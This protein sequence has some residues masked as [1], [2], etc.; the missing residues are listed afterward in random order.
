[1][2]EILE[3]LSGEKARV[4]ND[5]GQAI[6]TCV[7]RTDTNHHAFNGCI[8]WHSS[9]H[10]VWAL[11]AIMRATG[12][13]E[14]RPLVE[15]ALAPEKLALEREYLRERPRFEMPYGRAWFLRLA[16]D[17]GKLTGSAALLPMADAM[18]GTLIAFYRQ[19]PPYPLS[20]SY[21]S[22]SWAYI[23][24]LDY[25]RFTAD[26]EAERE[27]LA[28]INAHFPFGEISC[29]YDLEH[30]HFMAVCTNLA[31]LA[32][33]IMTPEEFRA[34]AGGFFAKSGLPEPV[35]DPVNWHHYGLNFS[36]A[37]GLWDIYVSTGDP[38]FADAYARHFRASFDNPENWRGSYRG[39][40]HWVAQFGMFALQPLF[41]GQRPV[42]SAGKSR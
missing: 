29:S 15:D 35:T 11:N 27:I 22:A 7:S 6:A 10:G 18:L 28:S 2:P 13:D 9:V 33:R 25:A 19:R 20:G 14:Y 8:D 3:R 12:R 16:I 4:A 34:W 30:G 26:D 41:D 40:G 38:A 39:V 1:M 21:N 31:M 42:H 17:H 37:W 36:R 24:M 23:N 5:L 32:A